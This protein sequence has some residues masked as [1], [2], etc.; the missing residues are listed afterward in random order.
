MWYPRTGLF[1]GCYEGAV[2]GAEHKVPTAQGPMDIA[3]QGFT[4]HVGARGA[5]VCGNVQWVCGPDG[6]PICLV[7]TPLQ[8]S[9]STAPHV[10]QHGECTL[11]FTPT[12][13]RVGPTHVDVDLA[14][15]FGHVEPVSAS[16]QWVCGPRSMPNLPPVLPDHPSTEQMPQSLLRLKGGHGCSQ[17]SISES[18]SAFGAA[19]HDCEVGFICYFLVGEALLQSPDSC[20]V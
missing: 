7:S 15:L 16:V 14:G 11:P 6:C 20:T 2:I 12:D 17:L 9:C 19:F 4:G 8:P 10:G 3:R 1:R 13:R 18:C 5:C